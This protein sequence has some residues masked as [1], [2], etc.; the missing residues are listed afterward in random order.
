[1]FYFIW[2][3]LTFVMF[4]TEHLSDTPRSHQRRR[5]TSF[6]MNWILCSDSDWPS[7][8]G[9]L[10]IG[11]APPK[12]TVLFFYSIIIVFSVRFTG[13]N[14]SAAQSL[15]NPRGIGSFFWKPDACHRAGCKLLPVPRN[16]IKPKSQRPKD[17]LIESDRTCL[18][19]LPYVFVFVAPKGDGQTNG[20]GTCRQSVLL[21]VSSHVHE[22]ETT[23][24]GDGYDK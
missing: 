6:Q 18:N 15:C 9:G 12:Q 23:V 7:S 16:A 22:A 24:Y 14:P 20:I 17:S 19:W 4:V 5:A 13:I 2:M 8:L 21:L 3:Q 11:C 10:P 1:M